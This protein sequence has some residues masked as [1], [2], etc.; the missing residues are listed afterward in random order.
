MYQSRPPTCLL[1]C[2]WARRLY[3][4]LRKWYQKA[5]APFLPVSRAHPRWSA[6]WRPCTSSSSAPPPRRCWSTGSASPARPRPGGRA[7]GGGPALA[8]G[9]PERKRHGRGRRS[10]VDLHVAWPTG[11]A[12]GK[13][14]R[15]RLT[16]RTRRVKSAL[17]CCSSPSWRYSER[18]IVVTSCGCRAGNV[19]P[20]RRQVQPRR[21]P[22]KGRKWDRRAYEAEQ[23]T[24]ASNRCQA[25]PLTQ[26]RVA[27][28]IPL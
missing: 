13:C 14:E 4:R 10:G 19:N 27:V 22:H 6:A 28:T 2:C 23:R 20:R 18:C 16:S 24:T 1:S 25:K 15:A 8:A 11:H 7:G 12:R 9:S 17:L 21:P 26:Q 3:T 5:I